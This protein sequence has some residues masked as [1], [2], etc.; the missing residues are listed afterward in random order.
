[1]K[2]SI[3]GTNSH[4]IPKII[5]N[6]IDNSK[7][8]EKIWLNTGVRKELKSMVGELEWR[9]MMIEEKIGCVTTLQA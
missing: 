9:V 2:V 5:N 8:S 7:K 3:I 6:E 1:M 4:I